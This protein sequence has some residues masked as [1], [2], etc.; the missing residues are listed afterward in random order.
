M[1]SPQSIYLILTSLDCVV[2]SSTISDIALKINLRERI[3][4]TVLPTLFRGYQ[5]IFN[6]LGNHRLTLR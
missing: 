4:M 6:S 3:D 1:V 2:K 5:E